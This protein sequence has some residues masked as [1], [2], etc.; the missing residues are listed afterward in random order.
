MACSDTLDLFRGFFALISQSDLRFNLDDGY[1]PFKL[2][3]GKIRYS[4]LTLR[5]SLRFLDFY[6][7][8]DSFPYQVIGAI[9]DAAFA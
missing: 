3:K 2:Y 1:N 7:F 9:M 4:F 6:F 5:S 8:Q